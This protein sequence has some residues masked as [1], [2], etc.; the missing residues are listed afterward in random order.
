MDREEY[1]EKLSVAFELRSEELASWMAEILRERF[2]R[3]QPHYDAEFV[4]EG[5][6]WERLTPN[7]MIPLTIS[8]KDLMDEYIM[9]SAAYEDEE[10]EAETYGDY[11]CRDTSDK[12]DEIISGLDAEDLSE[13]DAYDTADELNLHWQELYEVLL[14]LSRV[15]P[16]RYRKEMSIAEIMG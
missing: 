16:D 11:W 1:K 15:K 2:S 7:G 3:P 13:D 8:L 6:G 9:P 4:D 10:Y 5:L 14:Y 12:V